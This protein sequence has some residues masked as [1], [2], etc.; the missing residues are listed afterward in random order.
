MG[1]WLNFDR[2][3]PL[4]RSKAEKAYGRYV[5][6]E[7]VVF[8]E[9]IKGVSRKMISTIKEI[10]EDIIHLVSDKTGWM[11]SVDSSVCRIQSV[12]TTKGW[13]KMENND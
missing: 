11:S 12:C 5:G 3:S 1:K 6:I 13:G 8:Y 4:L 7:V 10:D 2:K 9:D